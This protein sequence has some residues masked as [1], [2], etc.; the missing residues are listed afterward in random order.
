MVE[1][2]YIHKFR[3]T[4]LQLELMVHP[5]D[6]K[7]GSDKSLLRVHYGSGLRKLFWDDLSIGWGS[8]LGLGY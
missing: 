5:I 6:A 8:L 3:S 7:V 1:K 2:K 4:T